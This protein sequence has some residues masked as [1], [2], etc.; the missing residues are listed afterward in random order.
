MIGRN[1]GSRSTVCDREVGDHEEDEEPDDDAAP[2]SFLPNCVPTF[3]C[4]STPM[5]IREDTTSF[6]R[7]RLSSPGRPTA[8]SGSPSR[9]PP[10]LGCTREPRARALSAPGSSRWP[11]PLTCTLSIHPSQDASCHRQVSR[12]DRDFGCRKRAVLAA[13]RSLGR[14][15]RGP[16]RGP[17]RLV[18][19]LLKDCVSKLA[20]KS[21]GRPYVFWSMLCSSSSSQSVTSMYSLTMPMRVPATPSRP[22]IHP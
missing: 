22:P 19:V 18:V 8:R 10:L 14:A 21:S 17:G 11:R 9:W 15:G 2:I 3:W 20:E 4:R 13:S 1:V 5:M 7:R 6:P 12:A 16:P